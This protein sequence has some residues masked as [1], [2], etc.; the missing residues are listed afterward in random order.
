[1]TLAVF[2]DLDGTLLDHDSYSHEAAAP[3]LT[4][5]RAAGVPLVLSSSKTAAEIAPLHAA[6]GLAPAPYIVE[7]GAGVVWHA[8]EAAQTGAYGRIRAALAALPAPLR[9]PFRGFGDMN[10]A[11][12]VA[13]TGLSPDA[14]ERAR[15]RMFSEPGLW[16]GDAESQKRFETALASHGITARRG[17]R[18]LTL[19]AG[20]DKADA[21]RAVAARLG[22]TRTIA[23]G[24]APNDAGMIAAADLGVIVAN[25]HGPGIPPLP[26]EA[27]G[28]I[29]RTA[30]PGPAG[31]NDA[32]L[33]ALS[34]P[35][36]ALR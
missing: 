29:L 20:G 32:I 9:A 10:L 12:I 15:Q 17:G 7:N 2:S 14:A 13:A 8:Q 25:P 1:M 24:D 11:E 28:R 3:A 22:A 16:S 21:M 23:L 34:T 19:S 33:T 35:A 30:S 31:W 5:L 6:L 26:G 18:F 27:S 4:A 36:G